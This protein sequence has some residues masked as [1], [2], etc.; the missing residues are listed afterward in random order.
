MSTECICWRCDKACDSRK[1]SWV[2]SF[3]PPKG[4]KYTKA[5]STEHD[6]VRIIE[7]PNFVE[8]K[9]QKELTHL[10]AVVDLT[11]DILSGIAANVSNSAIIGGNSLTHAKRSLKNHWIWEI[12]DPMQ[13]SKSDQVYDTLVHRA[14]K[15]GKIEKLSVRIL[16]HIKNM[17]WDNT[18]KLSTYSLFFDYQLS[19]ENNSYSLRWENNPM[20]GAIVQLLNECTAEEKRKVCQNVREC[21]DARICFLDNE[22]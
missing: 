17:A 19:P 21:V 10:P 11:E 18:D 15:K 6:T 7:C 2:D 12:L 8:T 1:C 20:C 9:P 14:K 3:T 4:S 16:H 13:E 5:T 22:D